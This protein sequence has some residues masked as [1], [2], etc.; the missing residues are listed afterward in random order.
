[1]VILSVLTALFGC[2]IIGLALFG[3]CGRDLKMPERVIL[4]PCAI[5][6]MINEPLWINGIGF[7]VACAILIPAFMSV[8]KE[9]RK[10]T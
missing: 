7:V 6:L 10:L 3:W 8:K 1:M 9:R 2:A 4:V 5:A